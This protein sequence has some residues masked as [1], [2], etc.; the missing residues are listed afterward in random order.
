[1]F[2]TKLKGLALRDAICKL[3]K[4]PKS[5]HGGYFLDPS[6]QT[7]CVNTISESKTNHKYASLGDDVVCRYVRYSLERLNMLQKT[8]V[9]NLFSMLGLGV[10]MTD[11]DIIRNCV[12]IGVDDDCPAVKAEIDRELKRNGFSDC[13]MYHI[14]VR[15]RIAA[16][17]INED[18]LPAMRNFSAQ[19][20]SNTTPVTVMPG[21]FVGRLDSNGTLVGVTSLTG[22]VYYKNVLFLLTAGH[23]AIDVDDT[24][25]YATPPASGTYPMNATDLLAYSGE[26]IEIGTVAMVRYGGYYD[27]ASIRLT[28]PNV[29][30]NGTAYN[31]MRPELFGGTPQIGQIVRFTGVPSKNAGELEYGYCRSIQTTY[32]DVR[33]VT[34]HDVISVDLGANAGTSGGPLFM[35][36]LA[37][38]NKI[39]LIGTASSSVNGTSR[40]IKFSNLMNDFNLTPYFPDLGGG[41]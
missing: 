37:N 39:N 20:L 3:A 23:G 18:I 17:V 35:N 30:V 21:G 9:E 5:S 27:F 10:H 1:M 38:E 22:A 15:D 8:V 11:V 34:L 36:D 32:Q 19:P 33:G 6:Q 29:T 41:D 2:A 24:I 28:N 13:N 14:G 16:G 26:L 31:G 12:T 25:V 7:L 4:E 40:F